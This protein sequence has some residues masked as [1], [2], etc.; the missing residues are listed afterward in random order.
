[1]MPFSIITL[2]VWYSYCG[3]YLSEDN[4]HLHID[5]SFQSPSTNWI[6]NFPEML[7]EPSKGI[8]FVLK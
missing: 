8:L 2:V 4:W 1:M 7:Y 3:A 5:W 6:S